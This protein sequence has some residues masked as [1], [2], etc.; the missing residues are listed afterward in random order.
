MKNFSWCFILL[1]LCAVPALAQDSVSKNGTGVPADGDAVWPYSLSEQLNTYV[2]DMVPFTTSMGHRFGIAPLAK[3]YNTQ[4]AYFNDLI[5]AQF[6][7]QDFRRDVR[8][9]FSTYSYW[10]AP[11]YGVHDTNNNPGADFDVGD[12]LLFDSHLQHYE[13]EAQTGKEQ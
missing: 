4:A 10:N 5:N 1:A 9:P 11:G 8:F 3:S 12:P 7:S 6:I 13:A 2:V